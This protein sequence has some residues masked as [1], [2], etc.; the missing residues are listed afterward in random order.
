VKKRFFLFL[1][2]YLGFFVVLGAYEIIH[3]PFST[4][5]AKIGNYEIK[6]ETS[7]AVP[8]VGKETKI[9]FQ[10]LDENEIP[11]DKFRIGIQIYHNDD[12][13]KSFPPTDYVSGRLDLSYLFKESGNHIIRADLFDLKTG[14]VLSYVF[15]V[16]V[17]NLYMNIF[18]YLIIAGLAGVSSIPIAII[19][20]Q[21]IKKK[22]GP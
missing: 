22:S 1:P 17:L 10:V 12:I 6:I 18:V 15:N 7:P 9:H 16:G 13:V 2:I 8:E 3:P 5:S 21:K 20:F 4:D 11:L 19:I 14:E